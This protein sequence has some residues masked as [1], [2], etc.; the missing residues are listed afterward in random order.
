MIF[1]ESARVI[2]NKEIAFNTYESYIYSPQIAKL[3]LPGQFINI[4]PSADWVNVMRRPM[5]IASQVDDS[6][7]IIYKPIGIGTEIMKE[8]KVNDR[9]DIIGPLG[10]HWIRYENYYPILIGGGVGIAPI[11]NLHNDL[12]DKSISHTLIM[13][14]QSK[15]DHFIEHQPEKSI[16]MATDD[17]SVGIKGNVI[18]VLD[19]LCSKD[20]LKIFSC[21][22]PAMMEALKV[23]SN[24]N[25]I[26]C[27]LAL[28]TVMACGIGICQGCSV[29]LEGNKENKHSYRDKFSLVCMDGPIFDAKKVKTCHI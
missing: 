1:N 8:W 9:V 19:S 18:D 21:G 20:K 27:D 13:R 17:G 6:I 10:N 22:P 23:Y 11:L 5:S 16:Y 29:E 7:S 15:R 14:A 28:E 25:N 26:K 12:N 3:A 4:L 2:S 24:I